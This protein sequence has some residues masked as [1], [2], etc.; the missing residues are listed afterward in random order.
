MDMSEV[1]SWAEDA[2]R[3]G[4][5]L[6]RKIDVYSQGWQYAGTERKPNGDAFHFRI[7]ALDDPIMIIWFNYHGDGAEHKDYFRPG[8]ERSA[9]ER[10]QWAA[11]AERRKAQDAADREAQALTAKQAWEAATPCRSHPYLE[12]SHVKAVPGL[13]V[14]LRGTLL[15]PAY[16]VEDWALRTVQ[17]IFPDGEKRFMPGKGLK[18]GTV[19][20]IHGDPG[21][22]LLLCE[23]LATGI[24]LF[25]ATGYH[26]FVAWDAGNLLPASLELRR[27][28]PER[29][30]IIGA[31]NDCGNVNEKGDAFNTGI[32]KAKAAAREIGAALAIPE[33]WD[34]LGTDWNDVAIH[35]M[36]FPRKGSP[37]EERDGLG[38][39]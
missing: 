36:G 5:G 15:V 10:R 16:R 3:A 1:L 22:P 20:P 17:R 31:D 2:I 37:K 25:E 6:P 9:L 39:N 30:I 35:E 26:V 8:A 4:G 13:R 34:G 19:F 27:K 14:D 12:F 18:R 23:G 7:H 38:R 11:Q 21:G 29:E 33:S 28:W 24:S 32:E